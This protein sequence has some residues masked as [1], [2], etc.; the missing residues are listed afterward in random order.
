M[1][2]Y[3]IGWCQSSYRRKYDGFTTHAVPDINDGYG[4]SDRALCGAR[5]DDFGWGIV[6]DDGVPGCKRCR[7]KLE[8]LGVINKPNS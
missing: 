8:S 4:L 7:A 2:T 5:P 3:W 1:T 6:P